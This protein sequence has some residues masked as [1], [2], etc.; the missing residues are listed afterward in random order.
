MYQ[1]KVHMIYGNNAKFL[2]KETNY[3]LL[4]LK[5]YLTSKKIVIYVYYIISLTANTSNQ[6][7]SM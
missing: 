1:Y 5:E 2:L 3:L 6:Y 4:V 7:P